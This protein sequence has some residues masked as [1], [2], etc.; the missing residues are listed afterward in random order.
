MLATRRDAD[1]PADRSGFTVR[2]VTLRVIFAD[3]NY[4]V[5]AGVSALLSEDDEIEL[6]TAVRDADALIRRWPSIGPMRY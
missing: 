1:G 2:K 4:L 6:V 5:R 3:D